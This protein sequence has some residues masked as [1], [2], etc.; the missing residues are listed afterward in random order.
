MKLA[1][2]DKPFL[3]ASFEEK[4][5]NALDMGFNAFEIDGRV[6][7][8]RFNEVRRAISAT[9]CRVPTACGGYRGWI[10]HFEEA[11][12]KE[13]IGDIGDILRHLGDIGGQGIVVPAAWGMFSRRLP[14]MIP[15]RTEAEDRAVLL[16][17]LAQIDELAKETGTKLYLEPL[18]RYED[19]MLNYVSQAAVLIQEGRFSNVQITADFFHMNLEE[20][21][22]NESLRGV[23][24]HL[25]HVHLAD[26]HRYQ[27]GHGHLDFEKPFQTLISIGYEGYL[28]F[29][30][31]IWADDE[32]AAYRDAVSFIKRCVAEAQSNENES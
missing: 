15:P 24:P 22:V 13:A 21:D 2:Q 27:P 28:A 29:E 10:G 9:G 18:N 6:L 11:R 32:K 20:P 12:R 8:E 30:C 23:A 19:H 7:M 1:T 14:P 4:F 25:G 16:D 31:R 5:Q 3:G 17:S 26:S